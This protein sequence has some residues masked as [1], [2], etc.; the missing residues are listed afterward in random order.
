MSGRRAVGLAGLAA[1]RLAVIAALAAVV[2]SGATVP[3]THEAS[4]PG[5]Y[6]QEH[7][8][9]LLA[10]SSGSALPVVFLALPFL[11]VTASRVV[12]GLAWAPR[13]YPRRE[14]ARAPPAPPWPIVGG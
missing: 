14:A 7:D 13:A 12:L 2:L 10:M 1:V 6:D 9:G 3:H 4:V 5:L 8:F 11:D